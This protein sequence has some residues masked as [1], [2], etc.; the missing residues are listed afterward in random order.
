MTPTA[1]VQTA[2]S[3]AVFPRY[4]GIAA[5]VLAADLL[6]KEA[7][8]RMLG[9]GVSV[10]LVD[11]VSLFVTFNKGVVGGTNIGSYTLPLNVLV[12]TVALLLISVIVR[13]LA[14]V[15]ARSVSALAL[16]FG[17]AL[18]NMASMLFG[19][20]GVADFFAVRLSD[21][22]TIVMNVADA[23]LWI[24]A[25]LLLPV[26]VRLARAVRAERALKPHVGTDARLNTL[27]RPGR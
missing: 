12:T 15:D 23:A 21:S 1:P 26:V 2:T 5:I 11:R 8:V 20:E 22:T 4:L 18:G 27:G 13:Q 19:P 6:S 17:G 14:A 9:V 24:G 25:L 16:V 10:P 3:R 7:A